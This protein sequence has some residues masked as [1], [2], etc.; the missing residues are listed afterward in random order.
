MTTTDIRTKSQMYAALSAGL[1]GNTIPQWYDAQRWLVEGAKQYPLW[2]VRSVVGGGDP[3]MRLNVPVREVYQYVA[4]LFK[5]GEYNISPMIDSWAVLRAEVCGRTETI[6][7]LYVYYVPP[8]FID[9]ESPWRGSFHKYGKEAVGSVARL[10]LE[11]YL[12]PEDL[13]N[14]YRLLDEYPGH[15]VEFSACCK[16]VGVV[17]HRNTVI[18]EVRNY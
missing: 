15:T 5:D 3:R 16:A 10:L 17:P 6:P 9:P 4:E 11:T 2:G 14:V 12:W 13:E 8:G 1:L 7:G 18:W